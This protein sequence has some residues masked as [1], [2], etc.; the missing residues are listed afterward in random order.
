MAITNYPTDFWHSRND[1]STNPANAGLFVVLSYK[2]H[3]YNTQIS[4]VTD[5][6]Y[7]QTAPQT[8]V[9]DHIAHF[10]NLLCQLLRYT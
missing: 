10:W 4:K 9:K 3:M 8:G 1:R 2:P 6:S 7:Y 5:I